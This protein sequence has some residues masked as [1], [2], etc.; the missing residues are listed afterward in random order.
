MPKFEVR[1]PDGTIYDVNAPDGATE[2]DAIQY[3]RQKLSRTAAV[4]SQ[5]DNDAI[6]QGAKNFNQDANFVKNAVAAFGGAAPKAIRG[7]KQLF[8]TN[9]VEMKRL[10]EEE[11]E[12]R[13]LDAPLRSTAGGFVGGLL[14][15][16]AIFAPAMMLPG[17]NT[18][19]GAALGGAMQ[20][21][22]TPLVEDESRLA[23][24]ALGGATGGAMQWA[25]PK[26]AQA[27]AKRS[28]NMGQ[29]KSQNLLRDSALKAGQ[30][31]GMVIPPS[32]GGGGWIN[33]RLES[34]AG[35]AALKQEAQMRNAESIRKLA[36]RSV[37]LN[38]DDA[39][40]PQALRGVRDAAGKVGY[41]PIDRM[42]AVNW[43]PEYVDALESISKRLGKSNARVASL[44]NPE[45]QQLVDE[46]NI[47]QMTGKELNEL[48]KDLREVGNKAANTAYGT[49]PAA[50]T[51]GKAQVEAS[52][53]L[54]DLATQN[55]IAQGRQDLI[56]AMRQARETIAKAHTVEK[57][58]NPATGGISP[59]PFADRVRKGLPITGE[60]RTIGE[61]SAAFPQFVRES[62]MVPTPGVSALEAAAAPIMAGIGS[63][64]SGSP[65][66]LIAGGI[67]LLRTPVRNMLLSQPY[68]K[69]VATP[70]YPHGLLG[71]TPG[72]VDSEVAR[73]LGRTL[74][75]V[76]V[77][78]A[79]GLLSMPSE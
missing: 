76:G 62:E 11:A 29:A 18:V 45:V 30:A 71:L 63:A 14:G 53:A 72:M 59:K 79:L 17:A 58:L 21:A 57:A 15:D 8:E 61:F 31:E 74:G 38:P 34:I 43:T 33:D 9:P 35:K 70:S 22:F 42:G 36:A 50:R 46:L 5:I 55:L 28:F 40:T 51:L 37:G 64:A 24:A 66:G 10:Q 13:R 20:G 65:A 67:P 73:L 47:G 32:A 39:I 12:S 44:R 69:L 49:S 56:P 54:E 68:Q 26:A 52:K 1:S 25:V 41:A 4:R 19:A 2:A 7:V 3:V 60:Q 48:I 23:R 75:P 27:L 16:A 77:Q 6:S 78:N